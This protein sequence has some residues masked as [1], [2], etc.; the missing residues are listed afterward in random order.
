MMEETHEEIQKE[1]EDSKNTKTDRG[2]VDPRIGEFRDD[3]AL[4]IEGGFI[5]VKQLD[6]VSAVRIF[7]AAQILS[8]TSV[9]PRIGLGYIA[10]NKLDLKEACRIFEE[11]MREEPDNDLAKTFFGICLLLDKEKRREGELLIQEVIG[12]TTD[13]TI[14]NLGTI[15]LEWADKDLRKMKSLF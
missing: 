9:A 3:F 7:R 2:P 8:P 12:R 4:L 13:P 6:E 15:S 10:L 11:V 5:A 1:G 14:K